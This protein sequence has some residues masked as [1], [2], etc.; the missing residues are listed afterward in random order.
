MPWL[1]TIC[2]TILFS[3][4]ISLYLNFHVILMPHE[5]MISML[6]KNLAFIYLFLHIKRDLIY[7]LHAATLLF[8]KPSTKVWSDIIGRIPCFLLMH[9]ALPVPLSFTQVMSLKYL[10]FVHVLQ[11]IMTD[12][13]EKKPR[14]GPLFDPTL[15]YYLRSSDYGPLTITNI[16]QGSSSYYWRW[17]QLS[18]QGGS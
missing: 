18:S 5:T 6:H 2:L 3:Y 9:S 13:V 14:G 4:C 1:I 7:M 11:L 12:S 17:Q 8:Y 10:L 16:L 15:H